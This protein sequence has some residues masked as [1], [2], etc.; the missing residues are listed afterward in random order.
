MRAGGAAV[1][2]HHDRATARP[3]AKLDNPAML[4]RGRHHDPR[5]RQLW[6]LEGI[7]DV[8]VGSVAYRLKPDDCLAMTLNAPISFHN[9]SQKRARY[10]GVIGNERALAKRYWR[11]TRTLGFQ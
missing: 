7:V 5:A 11:S 3:S 6:V 1:G 10:V 4:R 8:T 9:R 2:L